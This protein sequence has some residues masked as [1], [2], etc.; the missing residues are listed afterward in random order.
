M[1]KGQ[2]PAY[3]PCCGKELELYCIEANSGNLF[4]SPCGTARC[5]ERRTNFKSDVHGF[6]IEPERIRGYYIYRRIR[7]G[8]R[9]DK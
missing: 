4:W 5:E 9:N 2:L 1:S 8:D 6:I 7:Y 3:C